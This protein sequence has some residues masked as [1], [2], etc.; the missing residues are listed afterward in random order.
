M[1][2]R[3]NRTIVEMAR[4]MMLDAGLKK[5]YW[6]EAVST[7]VYVLNRCPTKAIPDKTP[8]EAWSGK[9]PNLK[10]L[11][12]FGCDALVHVPKQKRD[13]WDP[14][15]R[16]LLFM[17]YEEYKGTYR[18]IN[19]KT[20]KITTSR[21]VVFYECRELMSEEHR[22]VQSEKHSHFFSTE[23]GEANENANG[24][25]IEVQNT[26]EENS[27]YEEMSETELDVEDQ[28]DNEVVLENA[29]V[30]IIEKPVARD[31]RILAVKQKQ[32]PDST[33]QLRRSERQKKVKTLEDFVTYYTVQG[34]DHVF[35]GDIVHF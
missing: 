15:A 31:K 35:F 33:P 27:A 26:S 18:L 16:K 20:H 30:E 24:D 29:E 22:K 13:K 25:T 8:E 2:E 10:Y 6:A 34:I 11:R 12:V 28:T 4:T 19:P 14:K 9:K 32:P 7:A 21:N 17:G 1:A 5:N 23:K 3:A